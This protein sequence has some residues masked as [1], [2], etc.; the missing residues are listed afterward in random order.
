V[1]IKRTLLLAM[2]LTGCA[3]GP[4]F[5]PPTAATP[6]AWLAGHPPP[7][8]EEHSVPVAEPID[9][10]WWSL[11][12]DPELTRLVNLV[13]EQN[14]DVRIATIR[15]AE[16]RA[17]RGTVA[18]QLFPTLEGSGSYTREKPSAKGIFSAF[19]SPAASSFAS[20]AG[21]GAS[22]GGSSSSAGP[23]GISG[24]SIAPL[25]L[26]QVGFDASWE[27]DLWGR[28]RR[29]VESA[30]ASIDA[31]AE[32]RRDTLL[33]NLA[34]L[35][36]D[37]VQLRGVQAD[38]AITQD[39]IAIGQIVLRLTESRAN[40]GLTPV[41]D[42]TTARAQVSSIEA[43]L[44]R[45]QQ[46]EAM[47]INAIGTLLGQQPGALRNELGAAAPVPP[48]PP[49]VPIGVPSELARRRPDIREAEA[50]LHGATADIGVAVADFF[51]KVTLSGSVG[52]QSLQP[53]NLFSLAAGQYALGPNVTV[54]IFEGGKLKSTLELRKAQQREAAMS[55]QKVVLQALQEVDNALS[56]Y[57]DEQRRHDRLAAAAR[58][59][60]T[61][62]DLSRQLYGR[63][64]TDFLKVLDAQRTLLSARQQLADSG[65]TLSTGLVTLYKALGGGWE[66][67]FPEQTA[68]R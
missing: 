49:R 21:A 22:A 58:E 64:L 36:R 19:G 26:Y 54:P 50:Q 7:A 66:T 17:Q 65:T 20:G 38:I 56:A 46:Q 24:T 60:Q 53:K 32:A 47:L 48:V 13:A 40:S 12:D 33:N 62:L 18:S 6:T 10:S 31:S 39:S 23:G 4:D 5:R 68:S 43:G 42:V 27:L 37:Y 14:P 52:L 59:S 57:A 3:V 16:S 30:D 45:Q 2:L 41:L 35:V 67:R 51:P 34:E 1:A 11:F 29:S 28:V 44:P 55:Y 63:G 61:A 9:P 8:P 15:L 25:D